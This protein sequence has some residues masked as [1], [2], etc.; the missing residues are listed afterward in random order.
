MYLKQL[1]VFL[2]NSKGKLRDVTKIIADNNLNIFAFGIADTENF[3]IIRMIV[4][5]PDTAKKVLSDNGITSMQSDVIGVRLTHTPGEF[6]KILDLLYNSDISI[7]YSYAYIT[8]DVS[9]D[10][11]III[12]TG[13]DKKA[14]EVMK[15]ANIKFY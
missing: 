1:S 15:N 4:E 12:K 14:V 5:D 6:Y 7:E 11:V 2:E 13:D 8:N 3:G 9:D 10:A